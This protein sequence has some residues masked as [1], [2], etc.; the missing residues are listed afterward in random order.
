MSAVGSANAGR[1]THQFDQHHFEDS[2]TI[3]NQFKIELK[4]LAFSFKKKQNI[5][6][7]IVCKNG[8]A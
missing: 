7:I 6:A 1:K 2:P 8:F 4:A 5:T 3:N